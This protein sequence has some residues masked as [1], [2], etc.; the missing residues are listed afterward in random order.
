MQLL[1]AKHIIVCRPL[2]KFLLFVY[3]TR[4]TDV[5]TLYIN[6]LTP[7]FLNLC[8]KLSS[9]WLY[10][11]YWPSLISPQTIAVF[12]RQNTELFG[13]YIFRSSRPELFYE[14]KVPKNFAKFVKQLCRKPP[15][16]L[17]SDSDTGSISKIFQNFQEHLKCETYANN[18]FCILPS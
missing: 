13:E 17:K 5:T 1:P 7:I 4:N 12:S 6:S 2:Y 11:L 10:F 15:T 18:Y 9:N 16:L 8:S 3:A 14:K